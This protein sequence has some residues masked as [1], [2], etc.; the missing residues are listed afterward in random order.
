MKKLPVLLITFIVFFAQDFAS[1]DDEKIRGELRQMADDFL[2][3]RMM[4]DSA[5]GVLGPLPSNFLMRLYSHR[6]TRT[7]GFKRARWAGLFFDFK[8][9]LFP[10]LYLGG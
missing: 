8:W 4:K 2:N 7:I 10:C 5:F 9:R 3:F 1:A 6:L